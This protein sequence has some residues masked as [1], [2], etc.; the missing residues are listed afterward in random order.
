MTDFNPW[1]DAE[2][3]LR[4]QIS[5]ARKSVAENQQRLSEAGEI[6]PLP[7]PT[8]PGSRPHGLPE[9]WAF[10][11]LTPHQ[12]SLSGAMRTLHW[13]GHEV[14]KAE[15]ALLEGKLPDAIHWIIAANQSINS[16]LS[17][18]HSGGAV[19]MWRYVGKYREGQAINAGRN[20]T[21]VDL[22]DGRTNMAELVRDLA[23]KRDVL[24]DYIPAKVLWGEL[25]SLLDERG[26]EPEQKTH[27]NHLIVE[28]TRRYQGGEPVRGSY[29]FT[30]FSTTVSKIRN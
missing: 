12:L 23:K 4:W 26:A 5:L 30:S 7:K 17:R 16:A 22:D 8:K 18:W 11:N 15:A 6:Y 13:A 14:D 2:S 24:G 29:K 10:G 25:I 3:M 28:Y 27:E 1:A 21:T 9:Q 19:T 20:R